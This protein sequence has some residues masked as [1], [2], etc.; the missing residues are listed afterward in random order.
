MP[1]NTTLQIKTLLS[2]D[3]LLFFDTKS[4]SVYLVFLQIILWEMALHLKI[5][6]LLKIVL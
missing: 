6:E 2:L 4:R 3:F 1:F 5:L